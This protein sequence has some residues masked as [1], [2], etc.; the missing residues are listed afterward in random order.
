[1]VF[2][3]IRWYP[4]AWGDVVHHA[5]HGPLHGVGDS[6]ADFLENFVRDFRISSGHAVHRLNSSDNH[7]LAVG[8]N[9]SVNA[10]ATNREEGG[11]VLPRQVHVPP[12][13][14]CFKLFLDDGACFTDDLN[15]LRCEFTQGS[16]G[17]SRA[18]ERLALSHVDVQS[19]SQFSNFVFV[20]FT[21]RFHD[22][23]GHVFWK[24]ADVMMRLDGVP[25]AATGFDPVGSDG[26]LHE[27]LCT[28]LSLFVFKNT[29]EEFTNH[30]PLLFRFRNASKRF[31]IAVGCLHGDQID[32]LR[33]QKFL[34]LFGLV[35]SHKPRVNIHAVQQIANG[36]VGDDGGD[37]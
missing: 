27:V 12:F 30:L 35:L 6:S 2:I 9:I 13:C 7:G 3:P 14:C 25:N 5:V 21:Q 37:G 19:P 15:T 17:Q 4:E 33:F 26:T 36:F 22:G 34:D 32:A 1:M 10:D 20:E 8:P 23:Q 18:G 16:H 31:E 28:T 29:N 24:A 11:K